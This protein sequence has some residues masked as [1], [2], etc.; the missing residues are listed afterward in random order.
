MHRVVIFS[1]PVTNNGESLYGKL[2][3]GETE[4]DIMA[5]ATYDLKRLLIQEQWEG[6]QGTEFRE[7]ENWTLVHHKDGTESWNFDSDKYSNYMGYGT[8]VDQFVES[9]C[10]PPICFAI[11]NRWVPLRMA[12]CN[13]QDYIV[14]RAFY[15]MVNEANPDAL[16]W[17]LLDDPDELPF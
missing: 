3:S 11:L 9:C 14:S 6:Q 2:Y 10:F 13:N 16:G 12:D 1:E 8:I 5:N 4:A 17:I 7:K 15:D